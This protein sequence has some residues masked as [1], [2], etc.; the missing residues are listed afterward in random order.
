MHFISNQIEQIT[1]YPA[2]DF[3]DN[4]EREF[5]SIIHPEDRATVE[6]AVSEAI[7][8]D[9]PFLIEYRIVHRDGGTRHVWERGRPVQSAD[10]TAFL[11]GAIF[12]ILRQHRSLRSA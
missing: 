10:G 4:A 1:G 12:E 2:T 8:H 11:D 3:I 7:E 6:R 5:A 9:Q